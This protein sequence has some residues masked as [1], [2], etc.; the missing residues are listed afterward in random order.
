MG[1]TSDAKERLIA[2]VAEL[3]YHRGYTAVGVKEV[4][5]AAGVNKGSFYHFFSSKR[6]LVL[7]TL[8]AQWLITRKSLLDP[9]FGLDLPVIERF[10]KFF[11]MV[12]DSQQ[13]TCD[14]I[15]GCFFG[16]LAL[17]LSTQ[18]EAIRLKLQ[19]IFQQWTDYFEQVLKE[20]VEAGELSQIDPRTTALAIL[21]FFEG[22]ALLAKTHN[23][24]SII[25]GLTSRVEQL[26][27]PPGP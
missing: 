27:L 22:A 11:Q 21:A 9:V 6:D 25:E 3:M 23:D 14:P 5:D 19:S 7:T 26:I 10:H 2:S 24:F 1:R 16:N 4:C 17:E 15:K 13:G 12:A 18:D 20:A 8:E